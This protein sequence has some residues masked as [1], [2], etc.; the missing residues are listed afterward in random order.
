M[1]KQHLSGQSH[2]DETDT[3]EG[4]AHADNEALTHYRK[5]RLRSVFDLRGRPDTKPVVKVIYRWS[6]FSIQ[7]GSLALHI[8]VCIGF[9][10]PHVAATL[11]KSDLYKYPISIDNLRSKGMWTL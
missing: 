4:L 2:Q 6:F 7:L 10:D 5:G 8:T 3:D 1:E 9:H 11:E